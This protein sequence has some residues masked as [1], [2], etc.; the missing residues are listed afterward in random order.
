MGK[1]SDALPGDSELDPVL[2]AVGQRLLKARLQYGA[3][4]D[5]PRSVSQLEVGRLVAVTGVTV[6]A[7]EAGRND[8]GVPMLYRLADFYGV[9][10]V[11]L[12]TGQGEMYG[13]DGG[14]VVAITPAPKGPKDL[15]DADLA[16]K[17]GTKPMRQGEGYRS[18][19]PK[20]EDKREK[21]ARG[22]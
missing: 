16:T 12:L 18:P 7:W 3:R 21:K 15:D 14:N 4:L 22:G 13:D 8:A 1:S 11:W 17:M 10:R 19:G 20:R 2:V 9:L 5:P 6:G